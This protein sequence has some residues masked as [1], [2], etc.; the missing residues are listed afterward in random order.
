MRIRT[1]RTLQALACA[2]PI[3]LLAFSTG[4]PI[5]RTGAAVDGGLACNVCH[6]SF[7]LND[8]SG[9]SVVIH[10]NPYTPGMKQIIE[11]QVSHPTA[12]RFGFQLTAR[13]VS[14]ETQEAGTFTADDNIRV[15][16]APAGADTPCGGAL[17]FAEHRQPSTNAGKPGPRTFTIEWTP[18]VSNAGPVI[19]YAAGNAANNNGSP[20]GDHIYTT[21]LTI[22]PAPATQTSVLNALSAAPSIAPN[23]WVTISGA[24]LATNSRSWTSQ[25]I[26]NGKLPTQLDGTGVKIN[27]KDAFVSSISPGAITV[28]APADDSAGDAIGDVPVQITS[29][30]SVSQSVTAKMQRFS[31][32]LFAS[33][34]TN[35][36]VAQH[37]DFSLIGPESPAKPGETILLYGGCFGDTDPPSPSGQTI[38]TPAALA[39]PLTMRIGGVGVQPSFA[40]LVATGVYQFNVTVP[41]STADGNIPVVATI[42]GISTPGTAFIPV[43]K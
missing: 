22:D 31:P 15:R 34:E 26:V 14:D 21:K 39:N 40:G 2:A 12:M 36:I 20:T 11:V 8:D 16:C 38:A 17:E 29:N 9:G 1:I 13:L 10:A 43:K 19:F 5:M 4:P 7:P 6:T 37:A 33:R 24:K 27:G 3:T 32:A 28:L 41:D 25:D 42:G 35:M 23:G 30:G 18:P